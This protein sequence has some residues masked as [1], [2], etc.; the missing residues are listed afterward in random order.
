MTLL[1]GRYEL[2]ELLGSGGMAEV[3]AAYDEV[4]RRRVAVKIIHVAQL[5]DPVSRERFVREARVAAGLQHPNTVA[6]FD[7]GEDSDRPFIVMEL[8][9]GQSLADRV[10]TDG[11]LPVD[12][13][14]PIIAGVLAGLQAAHDRGLVHRDV[15]PSNILLPADGGVKLVDFGIAT[16]VADAA[17]H[18]TTGDEVLGTPRYL[19]PERVAGQRATP[20]SDLY[21]LGAVMY[22]CLAGRPPFVADTPVALAVAHQREP[23]R[24]L[25]ELAPHVPSGI[26]AVAERAL[27]KNPADRFD[28]AAS[29]R[30][31]LLGAPAFG[32]ADSPTTVLGGVTQQLPAQ[33]VPAQPGW[34]RWLP[35]AIG[36][37]AAVL[38]GIAA[39]YVLNSGD[40]PDGTANPPADGGAETEAE[41]EQDAEPPPEDEPDGTGDQPTDIDGLIETVAAADPGGDK[42]EDLLDEL[43]EL[44][45]EPDDDEVRKLIE[46]VGK[47][48]DEG[49]LDPELGQ[50]AIAVLE[51]QSRPDDPEL[52]GVSELFGEVSMDRSAWGDKANNLS[53]GLR[54]LLDTDPPGQ[55]RRE[56]RKLTD[57]LA[58]WIEKDEI[59]ADRGARAQD[60]LSPLQ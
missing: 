34:R 10:R 30:D 50:A 18:L 23:V 57:E 33:Q 22:E 53:S 6:V 2:H 43:N 36:L 46:E 28:S 39:A 20:A 38:L 35:A 48:T 3:Y 14:V 47:W 16:V 45:A 58:K 49:E 5:R 55:R 15:K 40:E 25:G 11:R 21:S 32:P 12:E 7:V 19:A 52:A 24:P 51:E 60:V 59:D 26:A 56:A 44:A 4:L 29:M 37:L 31:A 41:P 8:L 27:A 17:T 13:A 42:T 54:K 1:A 9:E